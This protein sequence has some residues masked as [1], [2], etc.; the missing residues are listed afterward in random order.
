MTDQANELQPQPPQFPQTNIQVTPQGMIIQ[1]ILGPSTS[2][3]QQI[4]EADMN[5][6]CKMWLETRKQLKREQETIQAVMR[7]KNN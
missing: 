1:V 2:I 6:I 7:S 5:E 3:N 4:G